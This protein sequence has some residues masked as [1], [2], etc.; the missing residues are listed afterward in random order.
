MCGG[1]PKV[2]KRDIRGEKLEADREATRR[3]NAEIAARR[4]K[5][6][7][8]SL[9]ANT[10]GAAGLGTSAISVQPGSDTLG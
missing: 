10:G 2:E 9:I 8:S 7:Q 5:R 6:A 1:A 3:A 4:A